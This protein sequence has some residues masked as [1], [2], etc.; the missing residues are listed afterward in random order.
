MSTYATDTDLLHWEPSLFKDATIPSQTLLAGSGDLSGTAFT[1][2]AG[3]FVTAGVEP[4]HVITLAGTVNG[5]FP[6]IAVN[7]ATSLT[8][9][10][11]YDRLTPGDGE[12]PPAR[13]IGTAT[14]VPFTIKTAR[15]Q[16]TLIS[17]LLRQSIDVRDAAQILNPNELRRPVALG[18]LQLLYAATA[19][20]ALE[21]S[22]LSVRAQ[23]YE[24]LYRRALRG[25][26]IEI[27]ANGDGRTDAIRCPAL[28]RLYRST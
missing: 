25:A 3:S 15:P 24:R 1:I 20:V 6:V 10:V 28:P 23:M 18:T 14:S 9:S 12:L 5:S 26:K 7:S 13:P 11:L 27:D 16:I 21:D 17:E 19:A 2:S 4:G 8:I 22:S